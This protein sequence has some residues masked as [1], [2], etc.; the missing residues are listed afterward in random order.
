MCEA[1]VLASSLGHAAIVLD[2]LST[3][4]AEK[5]IHKCPHYNSEEPVLRALEAAVKNG[6]SEAVSAI[7]A[8]AS[9]IV[10]DTD[11]H[12]VSAYR[13]HEK[14]TVPTTFFI[15]FRIYMYIYL[16]IATGKQA[17]ECCPGGDKTR[18]SGP[19]ECASGCWCKLECKYCA[20]SSAMLH[21]PQCIVERYQTPMLKHTT[22]LSTARRS[23]HCPRRTRLATCAWY[24]SWCAWGLTPLALSVMQCS[25]AAAT[26]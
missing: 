3:L 22:R 4:P 15:V 2:I 13:G 18:A 7:L 6:H 23:Y 19:A 8:P 10:P 14:H 11:A 1:L 21:L 16:L 25:P 17:G 26:S 24:R 5:T 20:N 12:M 9:G